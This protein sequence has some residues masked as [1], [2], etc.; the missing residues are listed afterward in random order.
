MKAA[1]SKHFT[2]PPYKAETAS[3]DFWYVANSTG[4][5]CLTFFDDSGENTGAKFTSEVVARQLADTW[6][7][8]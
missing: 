2:F 1:P 7:K 8:G 6:N 4:F 3:Y 5:N